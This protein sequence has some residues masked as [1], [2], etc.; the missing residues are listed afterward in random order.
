MVQTRSSVS[1]SSESSRAAQRRRPGSETPS[2]ASANAQER[3]SSARS[4]GHSSVNTGMDLAFAEPLLD[5]RLE[6]PKT[7]VE[8][9]Q[10]ARCELYKLIHHTWPNAVGKDP[11]LKHTHVLEAVYR[12]ISCNKRDGPIFQD[13]FC[14]RWSPV[15]GIKW[16]LEVWERFPNI[17]DLDT[18]GAQDLKV[19]HDKFSERYWVL[20][21]AGRLLGTSRMACKEITNFTHR[22]VKGYFIF[23]GPIAQGMQGNAEKHVYRCAVG[24]FD[25][26]CHAMEK[27]WIPALGPRDIGRVS[28]LM[29]VVQRGRSRSQS[30]NSQ[31]TDSSESSGA[32]PGRSRSDRSERSSKGSREK[33]ASHA[34]NG[35]AKNGMTI[36]GTTKNGMLKDGFSRGEH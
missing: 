26:W 24:C 13:E 9:H 30:S 10:R 29:K 14:A 28:R 35:I 5:P 17:K 19:L 7:E 11:A 1:G 4:R 25:A 34:A 18:I 33:K 3:A 21:I 8:F 31:S 16:L 2:E 32:K 6:R 15:E 36:N 23:D 27:E 22:G 12:L 20:A